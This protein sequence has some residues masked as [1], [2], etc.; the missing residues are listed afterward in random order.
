MRVC[1]N[2]SEI[3]AKPGRLTDIELLLVKAHAQAGYDILKDINFPWPIATIVWQHHE[4]LDGSGYPQ[5]IKN[6]EILLESRIMAVADVV[7]AIASHRPYR[8]S[9]GIDAALA[10]IERG[11]GIVYDPVVADACV[12]LFREK[13]YALPA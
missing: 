8:A 4:R 13:S 6:G 12:R 3:L 7:E 2:L 5:G 10:E 1:S 11:R 9:L